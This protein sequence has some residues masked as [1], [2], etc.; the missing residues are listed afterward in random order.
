LHCQITRINPLDSGANGHE[1]AIKKEPC[2]VD[3][4]ALA[5]EII[6]AALNYVFFTDYMEGDKHR[7]SR[8]S[9]ENIDTWNVCTT[10]LKDSGFA[11]CDDPSQRNAFVSLAK[12]FAQGRPDDLVAE[13]DPIGVSAGRIN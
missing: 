7:F 2:I 11:M 12:R 1:K 10:R 4:N 6:A 13:R 8:F 9:A 5:Q 3:G